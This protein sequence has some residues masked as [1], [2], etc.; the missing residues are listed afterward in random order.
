MNRGVQLRFVYVRNPRSKN[1]LTSQSTR[2][3]GPEKDRQLAE[4]LVQ[5]GGVAPGSEQLELAC[6]A[7]EAR[8]RATRQPVSDQEREDVVAVLAFRGRDVHLEPVP[9]AEERFGPSAIVDE[10]VE[11]REQR[12]AVGDG[13]V[14]HF[15]VR[16]PLALLEPDAERP[17][18]LLGQDP[19]SLAQRH[20][21]CLGV[22]AIGQVPEPLSVPSTHY[23]EGPAPVQ[24]LQHHPDLTA[25]EPAVVASTPAGPVLELA[26]EQR[27]ALLELAQHVAAKA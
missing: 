5:P 20:R 23:R 9:K 27:T 7:I 17:K 25:A 11:R 21:V 3:L 8:L 19:L 13:R 12:D 2:Y 10:A 24:H 6:L 4:C 22:P 14:A 18:A 15:R 16:M 1:R 26:A